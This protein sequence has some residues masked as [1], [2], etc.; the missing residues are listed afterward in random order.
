M[1]R[2]TFLGVFGV[3]LGYFII[4]FFVVLNELNFW[5][6]VLSPIGA[7][8]A[9]GILFYT[10]AKTENYRGNWLAVALACLSWAVTDILW[11]VYDLAL[12]I[13]PEQ[14]DMF[15]YLYLLPNLFIA[16]ACGCY[17]FAQR[18][19][20][21]RV[22]LILD[23]SAMTSICISLIWLLFFHKQFELLLHLDAVGLT[24]F[25]YIVTDFFS[26][27][28]IGIIYMSV[29]GK[30]VPATLRVII[31]GILL[32]TGADLFYSYQALNDS[33]IPN[34]VIDSVYMASLLLLGCS[35]LMETYRPTKRRMCND[36]CMPINVL[37][38]RKWLFMLAAPLLIFVLKGFVGY[39][40]LF[41][42]SII[43]VYQTLSTYVYRAV[44]NEH[45]L[46]HEKKENDLLEN[47]V[48]QRTQDLINANQQLDLLS[49]QDTVTGLFNR[50]YF[51]NALDESIKDAAPS[52]TVVLFFM[53]LDR[54]KII[55]DS[56]GHDMGDLVL[57]E[58]AKRFNSWKSESMTLA[59]LGGDEFTIAMRGVFDYQ[60]IEEV[61]RQIVTLISGPVIIQEHRFNLSIS[62]GIA[63][64]PFDANNSKTLMKHADIAMYYAKNHGYNE[65][66]FFTS[67]ISDKVRNKNKI[68]L[69]LK[70]A[71]YDQEFQLFY[72][73][74]F[75]IPENKLM[76]IEALIR[77]TNPD[78]GMISPGDFIP[79]AEETG[80]ISA[81]G[82]WV[83]KKAVAQI[84]QWNNHYGLNLRMGINIS[85][86][87]LDRINFIESLQELI[88]THTVKPEWLDIEITE[89]S[90]M[91]NESDME[92]VFTALANI[93]VS[94]SMD[95]FGTGYSSLSYIKRFDIDCLKISKPL[96]DN[97]ATDY[98]NMQ[99]VKAIVMMAE[100]MELR[101][102]AEG[103]E[104]QSQ[105]DKLIE[106]GCHEVQGYLY[107]RPLPPQ[108]F[109]DKF[110][111]PIE[112]IV[113]IP[114]EQLA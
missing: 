42:L 99:I 47:L 9:S 110:L 51:L 74:Q 44:L 24:T 79:I 43:V 87:Q 50:R 70:T 78:M 88:K 96:I 15:M 92:E 14:L 77:W 55:N 3:L 33:Y 84:S 56:Y 81:I 63:L 95:D 103:V 75:S 35:G 16:L 53:D 85:P 61:A 97:I 111:K 21:N 71:D 67:C 90:A 89:N 32:Y 26:L 52:D 13:N 7:L 54:F 86:K 104:L 40:I 37:Y 107:S 22:Q 102:I 60:D 83:L 113:I 112:Q 106:A 59:R 68:E 101:I 65:F 109:E 98:D 25:L 27:A 76:G 73:P 39:D 69:L 41:L 105:L 46:K 6:N 5:G 80:M 108:E 72:Q 19:Q 66:A 1:T 38:S 57:V 93:G 31:Y 48:S 49:K 36:R 94:I 20:W 91:K 4:Y 34:S 17:V 18:V 29:G 11:A 100:A 10:F 82:D 58:I 30:N 8:M 45:M 64:Y 2:K 23:I 62:I 114:Q 28:I 12:G